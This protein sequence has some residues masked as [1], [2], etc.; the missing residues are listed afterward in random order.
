MPGEGQV[1]LHQGYK[2]EPLSAILCLCACLAGVSTCLNPLDQEKIDLSRFSV[3]HVSVFDT[4]GLS[5][6]TR[7]KD[8][9]ERTLS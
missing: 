8:N 3:S 6:P 9:Y 1:Q 5:I 2:E 4:R 7:G